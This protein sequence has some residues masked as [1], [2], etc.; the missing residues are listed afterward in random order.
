MCGIKEQCRSGGGVPVT[1]RSIIAHG[2]PGCS[3]ATTGVL[4]LSQVTDK[5]APRQE[6]SAANTT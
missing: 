3:G 5:K 4:R 6:P 2:D 1:S